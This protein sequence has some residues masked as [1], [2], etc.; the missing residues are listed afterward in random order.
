M[1]KDL[2]YA[3]S[4][5][6]QGQVFVS[7]PVRDA[8]RW[9]GVILPCFQMVLDNLE[10][11]GFEFPDIKWSDEPVKIEMSVNLPSVGTKK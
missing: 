9:L 8:R 6:G 10:L 1:K 3:V 7:R 4:P 5:S 11:D 2:Y